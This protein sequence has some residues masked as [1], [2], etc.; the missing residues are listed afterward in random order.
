MSQASAGSTPSEVQAPSRS[1]RAADLAVRALGS[2]GLQRYLR[3]VDLATPGHS[4]R[5]RYVRSTLSYL[6]SQGPCLVH[7][8]AKPVA[9][10]YGSTP[11]DDLHLACRRSFEDW[12]PISRW[13][14]HL[15]ARQSSRVADLGAYSG[16]YSIT[17]A[18]TNPSA[19]IHAFEPNPTMHAIAAANIERNG[20]SAQIRLSSMAATDVRGTARL[21]LHPQPGETSMASLIGEGDDFVDVEQ[22]PLDELL[23]G[24]GID[25]MKVDVEGGEPA[26]F[27]GAQAT[28]RGS[29]PT[30]LAEA[31][32]EDDLRDQAGILKSLGYTD[33]IAVSPT[34]E[35]GDAR[36]FIW[37][38]EHDRA[39]AMHLLEQAVNLA[40]KS[41]A[42]IRDEVPG[43]STAK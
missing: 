1:V 16:V 24:E 34:S 43:D 18:L 30:I 42:L 5:A 26:V 3:L 4:A 39:E 37:T 15:K 10:M 21:Y 17:A 7:I 31:L 14:F 22:A 11:S 33:P 38:A 25:L 19:M 2:R 20:L 12:E 35:H 41:G 13:F 40:R 23:A 27:R 29:M 8:D 9:F 28:L 6:P 36:N 32:S